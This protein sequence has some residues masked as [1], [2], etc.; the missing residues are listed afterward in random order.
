MLIG[1]RRLL[2]LGANSAASV[3]L[4]YAL[5]PVRAQAR[6]AAKTLIVIHLRGGA[7]G[8]SMLVPYADPIY[9]RARKHTAIA[10]PGSGPH[11]A[12]ALDG[13]CG[14]HPALAPLAAWFESGELA[15]WPAVGWDCAESSHGHAER[16]LHDTLVRLVR[17]ERWLRLGERR[18]GVPGAP[19]HSQLEHVARAIEAGR[20][21]GVV[22]TDLHGWD[23]HVAQGAADGGRLSERLGYLANTLQ[24]LRTRLAAAARWHGV[25]VAIVTEFGRSLLEN[26]TGGTADGLASA[27][28]LAGG[29][30][31]GGRVLGRWP[32]LSDAAG[33]T[34]TTDMTQLLARLVEAHAGRC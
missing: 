9:Y 4:S 33:V 16:R 25:A 18:P 13:R 23:T 15:A 21:P 10:A 24:S 34:A 1:R 32:P 22:W 11:A 20:A 26:D 27:L 28:L 8:L 17:A 14:L 30:V 29:A 7:D 3:G 6:P 31:A 2:V 19:L 12:I 5:R